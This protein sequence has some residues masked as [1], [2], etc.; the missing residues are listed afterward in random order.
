[1]AAATHLLDTGN[2]RNDARR[3]ARQVAAARLPCGAHD[4]SPAHL[5]ESRAFDCI[6]STRHV[7]RSYSSNSARSSAVSV[8]ARALAASSFTRSQSAGARRKHKIERAASTG[9]SPFSGVMVRARIAAPR[10][11]VGMK[12]MTPPIVGKNK[13]DTIISQDEISIIN[14]VRGLVGRCEY[15]MP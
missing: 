14:P 9:R 12:L 8:P 3:V 7:M 4:E 10:S 1:M 6:S 5:S 11:V 13:Q 15:D 2:T